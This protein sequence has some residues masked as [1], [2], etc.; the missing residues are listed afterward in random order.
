MDFRFERKYLLDNLSQNLLTQAVTLH[1][2]GFVKAYP[3]RWINNIYFDTPDLIAYHDNVAGIS[4]RRKYRVRWYGAEPFTIKSPRFEIKIKDNQLGSKVIKSIPEFSLDDIRKTT[5]HVNKMSGS[6]LPLYPTLM[7]SYLRSYFKTTDNKFRITVD[8]SMT[9][10]SLLNGT[11]FTRYKIKDDRAILE[12]K[13]ARELD[14]KTDRITQFLP[15]RQTK[16]SKYITG[17]EFTYL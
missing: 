3:D 17:M 16:S 12:L 1:P 11:K 9:Y 10:F 14:R 13:Y 6:F 5:D 2:A 8:R 7:N 4:N 15:F